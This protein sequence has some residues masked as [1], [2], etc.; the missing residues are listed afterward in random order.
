MI[1]DDEPLAREGIRLRLASESDIEVVGEH[2]SAREAM[3]ALDGVDPDLLFLD[4]QMPGMTGIEML[5]EIGPDRI[6]AVILVTAFEEHALDAFEVSVVDY[7]LKPIDTDRFRTALGRARTR[8]E[9]VRA[10]DLSGRIKD[11]LDSNEGA[12][13]TAAADPTP[14]VKQYLTRFLVSNGAGERLVETSQIDWIESAG[15]YARLHEGDTYHLV[16]ASMTQLEKDLDPTRFC[17][18]HRGTIVQFD[19]IDEIVPIQHGDAEVRLKQGV[20]LRLSR[21]YREKFRLSLSTA[22]KRIEAE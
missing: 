12:V 13:A 8:L 6:P 19:R 2:G 7:V 4:V 20:S 16:R 14:P 3:E 11:L 21:S 22:S 17:R 10:V 5:H 15:D 1:V 18:I 9:R